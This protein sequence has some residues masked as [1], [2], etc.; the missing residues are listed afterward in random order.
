MRTTLRVQS[1][2]VEAEAIK[3]DLGAFLRETLK[4]SLRGQDPAHACANRAARFLGYEITVLAVD[5]VRDR[6]DRRAT[7]GQ[8]GFAS[9]R[10]SSGE[11]P[12]RSPWQ[13]G[14]LGGGA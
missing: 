5:H 6:H 11:V 8:I 1:T 2:R 4:L 9:P 7:N 3:R 14:R 13:A 12:V 10:T